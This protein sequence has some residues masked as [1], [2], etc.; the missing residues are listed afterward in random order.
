MKFSEEQTHKVTLHHPTEG[1]LGEAELRF[2]GKLGL[3]A[4]GGM[5]SQVLKLNSNKPLDYV[6]ATGGAYTFTL[7]DCR[8]YGGSLYPK[9]LVYGNLSET[10]FS[11]IEIQF[12]EV[13]EWFLRW[14]RVEGEVGKQLSWTMRTDQFSADVT[15]GTRQFKLSSNYDGNHRRVGEDRIVH[16][17]VE[18]N[19]EAASNLFSLRDVQEKALDLYT[20][21]SV[22]IAYPISIVS[23]NIFTRAGI[24]HALYFLSV[25]QRPRDLSGDFWLQCFLRKEVMDGRWSS[26]LENYYRDHERR[27]LWRRLVGMWRYEGYWEYKLVGFVS[28]LD[29]YV[30]LRTKAYPIIKASPGARLKKFKKDLYKFLGSQNSNQFNAISELATDT[31][32]DSAPSFGDRFKNAMS[33]SDKEIVA[34]IGIEHKDFELIKNVRDAVAHGSPPEVTD[35]DF[36]GIEIIIGK[37]SLLLTYWAQLDLGISKE[38]FLGGMKTHNFVYMRA[39]VD[40]VALARAT[41]SA[42]F[43]KVSPDEFERLTGRK[44]L[45]FDACFIEGPDREISLSKEYTKSWKTWSRNPKRTGSADV[46]LASVGLKPGAAKFPMT[47]YLESGSKTREFSCV[48][49]IDKSKLTPESSTASDAA[50]IVAHKKRAKRKRKA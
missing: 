7:C 38:Q 36:P 47:V 34:I 10:R 44:E 31:F 11:R 49:I 13:S 24:G 9:F 5:F 18:F 19:F 1:D 15:E 27:D 21:L 29:R 26:I 45:R 37:I 28:L 40:R 20:L 3:V 42:P 46:W 50:P 17:C 23:I 2:G 41:R 33:D 4:A 48:C 16:E 35:R 8:V 14:E 22:L 25:E 6:V 39:M 43:Y 32:G 12:S 30:D